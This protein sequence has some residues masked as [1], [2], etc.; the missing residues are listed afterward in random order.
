MSIG[1]GGF[2]KRVLTTIEESDPTKQTYSS[3]LFHRRRY[4]ALVAILRSLSK[5]YVKSLLDVGCGRGFLYRILIDSGVE[6]DSYMCLDI[7]CSKLND[8]KGL[9]LCADARNMPI[10]PCSVD[11]TVASEL[12]EHLDKSFIAIRDMIM[13][14]RKYLIITFP[15]ET[16]KNA[17]GF[18]YPEHVSRLSV[19][20]VTSLIQ[21]YGF[22]RILHYRLNYLVPP[23]IYDKILPYNESISRILEVFQKFSS[24]ISYL[25]MIRTE[26]LVF[27]RLNAC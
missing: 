15:D 22:R 23:S 21:R 9:P 8:V 18:K 10:T 5:G 17:L 14:T 13:V 26:I 16:V 6:V 3:Q 24:V 19:Q 1:Y 11:Y 7:D 20:E 27:R 4:R 2:I 12:L 25:N